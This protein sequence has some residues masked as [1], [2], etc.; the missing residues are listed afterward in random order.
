M[1]RFTNL[2]INVAMKKILAVLLI[3]LAAF[4]CSKGEATDPEGTAQG[5]LMVFTAGSPVTTRAY[6]PGSVG[7]MYWDSYDNLGVYACKDGVL[8]ASDFCAISS[9]CAGTNEGKFTPKNILYTSK[10]A[11]ATEAEY[12]FYAYYP[13]VSVPIATYTEGKVHLNVPAVQTG[14]F[15]RYHIC[16]SK[17][18]TMTG[19]SIAS[20]KMVRFDF[21][22]ASSMVRLRLVVDAQ[23]DVAET[24]IQQVSMTA[25]GAPLTGDCML[26]LADGTLAPVSVSVDRNTVTINLPKPVKVTQTASENSYLDFVILPGTPTGTISFSAITST[27]VRLT[28][29]EKSV[30]ASGFAAGTRYAIDRAITMKVNADTPDGY[31]VD[32]GNA[33]ESQVDNDGA[34]TD[35][36]FAW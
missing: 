32:G 2:N 7:T 34:Y 6:F 20:N 36:G 3:G 28:M 11:D 23:S 26:T 19:A 31:Y 15:G 25:E 21:A 5:G 17:P 8:Q 30:P 4:N 22:P 24:Y 14:E 18:V 1:G 13:Q 27:N 16:C 10:W 33:W 29:K 12:T 9:S 35:G